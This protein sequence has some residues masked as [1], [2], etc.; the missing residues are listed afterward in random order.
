MARAEDAEERNKAIGKGKAKQAV[1]LKKPA[2]AVPAVP[3]APAALP[4]GAHCFKRPASAV[5]AAPSPDLHAIFKTWSCCGGDADELP[6]ESK[7]KVRAWIERERDMV[8]LQYM[9]R[10][11]ITLTVAHFGR[12]HADNLMTTMKGLFLRG[13]TKEQLT[14]LKTEIRKSLTHFEN[15][16]S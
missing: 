13:F 5:P 11:V 8:Q 1:C 7:V 15:E 16:I 6:D 10:A 14:L 12:R 2:S 4:A 3:P 9:D